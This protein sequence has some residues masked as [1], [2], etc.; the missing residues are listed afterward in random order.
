MQVYCKNCGEPWDVIGLL[1]DDDLR[2]AAS[3]TKSDVVDFGYDDTGTF[4]AFF[5]MGKSEIEHFMLLKCACCKGELT[6]SECGNIL[7]TS[8]FDE[9]QMA[10]FCPECKKFVDTKSAENE[11]EDEYDF[12]LII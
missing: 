12:G 4:T 6:C 10:F 8:N 3:E 1:D 11:Y 5:Y 2:V 7:Q 9:L